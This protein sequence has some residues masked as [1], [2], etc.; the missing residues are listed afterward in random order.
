MSGT[1]QPIDD[2][3]AN[4]LQRTHDGLIAGDRSGAGEV[5]RDASDSSRRI[6]SLIPVLELL[7]EARDHET[8][9]E[10]PNWQTRLTSDSWFGRF[11]LIQQIG[12]GGHGIVFR[13]RDPELGREIALKLPRLDMMTSESSRARFRREATAAAG[14]N[15]PAIVTVYETGQSEGIDY[16]A[17]EYVQGDTLA[18]LIRQGIRLTDSD[19]AALVIRLAEAIQHAHQRGVLHRDIKPS[20]VLIPDGNLDAAKIADFGLAALADVP[21]QTI[22]GTIIGTPAYMS[23]EQAIADRERTD[24]RADV[25]ALGVV[26]YELLTGQQPF[27]GRTVVETLRMIDEEQPIAPRKLRPTINRDLEAVCLKCLEKSPSDRYESAAGLADDLGR[28]QRG[29]SVLARLPSVAVRFTRFSKR[30]PLAVALISLL[31][32]VGVVAPLVAYQQSQLNQDAQQ[33]RQL[34]ERALYRSDMNLAYSDYRDANMQRCIELLRRHRAAPDATDYRGFEWYYLTEVCR[35][36]FASGELFHDDQLESFAL[37]HDGQ[38]AAIGSFDGKLSIYN[39]QTSNLRWG[40]T[41]HQSRLFSIVFSPDNNIVATA[42]MGRSIRLWNITTQALVATLDG[43]WTMD[44]T[45]SGNQLVYRGPSQRIWV[46]DL[47]SG[48]SKP[49]GDVSQVRS[50]AVSPDGKRIAVAGFDHR[51]TVIE[52]ETGRVVHRMVGHDVPA[53]RI[54]YSANGKRVASGDVMGNLMIWDAET[55]NRLHSIKAHENAIYSM[56]FSKD[57]KSI[58]TGSTDSKVNLY[59]VED[60]EPMGSLRGHYAEIVGVSFE[61]NDQILVTAAIDGMVKRWDLSGDLNRDQ[62]SHPGGT[63][64]VDFSPDGRALVSACQNGS[65][66]LWNTTDGSL[67]STFQVDQRRCVMARFVKLGDDVALLTKG[68]DDRLRI[69]NHQTGTELR[70]IQ[71]RSSGDRFPL[72]LTNDRATIAFP[73]SQSEV[74]VWDLDNQTPQEKIAMGHVGSLVFSP[75]ASRVIASAQKN[76]VIFDRSSGKQTQH[77]ADSRLVGMVVHAPNDNVLASGGYDRQLKWWELVDL[78]DDHRL[79]SIRTTAGMSSIVTAIAYSADGSTLVSGGEDR[80]IRIWDL[81]NGQ[82][83]ASLH[84]HEGAINELAFSPD[85]Q[86]LASACTDFTVRLWR[87]PRRE[88]D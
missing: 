79:E 29:E 38:S 66:Y 71:C 61:N 24:E 69:W 58:A 84:G 13:A 62:L 83:L 51:V 65:V 52:T 54:D 60:A 18:D 25:Y 33:A 59:R 77:S 73:S 43:S 88:T 7:D 87:A 10:S 81:R 28:F 16:I 45:P 67:Q 11:Q 2:E 12:S 86:I 49:L 44:F 56:S 80:V 3:F 50:L 57:S 64:S 32:T 68:S 47:A 48:Q 22:T 15:H 14:L 21:D 85:G 42:D 75:D 46:Y 55:G 72:A 4:H 74:S 40:V 5:P 9:T 39:R 82:Q 23:P 31:S 20:N 8:Q 6:E 53:W 78:G 30:Y 1:D 35:L 27:Q 26:L 17:A 41:A 34:A 70:S 36:G 19:A 63:F 37:S 76:I